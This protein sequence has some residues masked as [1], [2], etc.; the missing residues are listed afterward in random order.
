M[1]R[2]DIFI[3]PVK[4]LSLKSFLHFLWACENPLKKNW[5][6][7]LTS[8]YL[9]TSFEHLDQKSHVGSHILNLLFTYTFL[10]Y[11]FCYACKALYIINSKTMQWNMY[12]PAVSSATLFCSNGPDYIKHFA[13]TILLNFH[14]FGIP[15]TWNLKHFKL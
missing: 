3:S 13:F 8:F 15:C 6:I 2:Y 1:Q 5:C 12:S 4:N 7:I 11:F 14:L 10:Y 9:V